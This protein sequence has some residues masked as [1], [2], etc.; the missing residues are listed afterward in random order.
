M[1]IAIFTASAI[2]PVDR[3]NTRVN[4][5]PCQTTTKQAGMALATSLIFLL[6]LT[7]FA[8]VSMNTGTLQQKMAGNL[9]DSEI[10]LQASESALRYG[11][12]VIKGI[13]DAAG[14]DIAKCDHAGLNKYWC[15]NDFQWDQKPFWLANGISYMGDG[16]KQVGEAFE[17]PRVLIENYGCD[18]GLCG[19]SRDS[20]M[21]ADSNGIYGR[22]FV[23]ITARGTGAS[24]ITESILEE[25][26]IARKRL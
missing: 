23:R 1:S 10:A 4:N 13:L 25:Y 9:R 24:G 17:D 21:V 8:V 22:A 11:E 6:I 5:A 3:M 15:L 12:R 26:Y 18:E 19:R 16:T 14:D 20:L 7:L 2:R